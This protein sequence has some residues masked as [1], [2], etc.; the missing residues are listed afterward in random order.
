MAVTHVHN[1]PVS[2]QERAR[3]GRRAQLLA[4]ASVAYNT[5]EAVVAV[6]AGLVAG[7]T[8]LVG[9]GLDSVLEVSSG[10]VVLWQFRHRLPES[11]EQRALRLIALSFFAL[12]AWVTVDALQAL[13]T[14]SEPEAPPV[15]AALAATSLV[16]MPFLSRAQ[17]R[18]GRALHSSSVVADAGQT[19]LC[20]WMSAVLL[21]GLL[22]NGALGWWWADPV[23]GLLIAA[24]AVREGRQAWRGEGCCSPAVDPGRGGGPA[25]GCCA[26]D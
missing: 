19:L 17:R 5:L 26:G 12:A 11:R 25:G 4:G 7:S 9:F 18:T 15:G 13:L 23:A 2:A 1:G 3:L 8:A 16:L 21:V 22:L 20:T 10:L 6:G 14:R 24:I